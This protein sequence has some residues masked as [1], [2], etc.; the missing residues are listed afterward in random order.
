L[1]ALWANVVAEVG[2]FRGAQLQVAGLPAILGP[3]ALGIRFP[4]DYTS[5]YDAIQSETGQEVIRRTL[6]LLTGREVLIRVEI[7]AADPHAAAPVSGPTYDLKKN[8]M[9]LPIFQKAMSTLGAQLLKVDDGFNPSL[10]VAA[11]ETT[12][13]PDD[14]PDDLPPPDPDEV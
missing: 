10:A 7:A 14:V 2:P 4:A 9:Q 1:P 3:N 5:Q 12:A 13:T 6:K 8:L 11:V